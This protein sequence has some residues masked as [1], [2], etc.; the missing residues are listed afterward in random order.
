MPGWR[1]KPWLVAVVALVAVGFAVFRGAIPLSFQPEILSKALPS[2]LGGLLAIAA[3]TERAT[4]VLSDIW[5]GEAHARAEDAVRLINRK[6]Q[7]ETRQAAAVQALA[8]D[9]V[10]ANNTDFFSTHVATVL[11][12]SPPEVT[13]EKE[14]ADSNDA[15]AAVQQQETQTRLLIA[16]V[17]ALLVSAVGVRALAALLDVQAL[18]DAQSMV[19]QA[20]DILLTA[21][22]L[23]GGTSGITEI[24]GLLGT[25]VSASRKRALE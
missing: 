11:S 7:S 25:Y 6:V 19:F 10:R 2:L 15:L 17:V 14:I 16:F 13:R 3:I 4:A 21:G 1:L 22:V 12:A 5:L 20:I 8:V 23:T 18:T 9:A 24:T